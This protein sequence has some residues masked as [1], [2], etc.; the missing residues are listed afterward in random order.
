MQHVQ[1]QS[2]GHVEMTS[3]T[4]SVPS[5]SND[6]I[7]LNEFPSHLD[8]TSALDHDRQVFQGN[9][10]SDVSHHSSGSMK[11]ALYSSGGRSR[12]TNLMFP[13][14][15]R[16]PFQCKYCTFSCP[17]ATNLSIHMRI[18]TGEKPY[19]CG[20]CSYAS[21]RKQNLFRHMATVHKADHVTMCGSTPAMCAYPIGN[22]SSG[23]ERMPVV[24]NVYGNVQDVVLIDGDPV[25]IVGRDRGSF[26]VSEAASSSPHVTP[27]FPCESATSS[28]QEEDV[29]E[30]LPANN[31]T[32]ITEFSTRHY[33]DGSRFIFAGGV[34]AATASSPSPKVDSPQMSVLNHQFDSSKETPKIQTQTSIVSNE[35]PS[36]HVPNLISP[37]RT[38]VIKPESPLQPAIYKEP[39]TGALKRKQ[40]RPAG[41]STLKNI[42]DSPLVLGSKACGSPPSVSSKSL[43]VSTVDHLEKT[44]SGIKII[45]TEEDLEEVLEGRQ[46]MD[47]QVAPSG[48]GKHQDFSPRSMNG[49]S[50]VEPLAFSHLRESPDTVYYPG[51]DT[52]P[53]GTK[54]DVTPS[55]DAILPSQTSMF[56]HRHVSTMKPS[57]ARKVNEH[58]GR[59]G[60]MASEDVIMVE[61][62]SRTAVPPNISGQRNQMQQSPQKT[63]QLNIRDHSSF[64]NK[65]GERVESSNFHGRKT[66]VR[67]QYPN[68]TFDV[69]RNQRLQHG[70]LP[71]DSPASLARTSLTIQ[72]DLNKIMCCAAR[73]LLKAHL[74]DCD[75]C[76]INLPSESCEEQCLT[77]R[78]GRCGRG[79]CS[80]QEYDEGY[81][82]RERCRSDPRDNEDDQMQSVNR[83]LTLSRGLGIDTGIVN[84]VKR[85]DA[86]I[87]SVRQNKMGDG[88]GEVGMSFLRP[89]QP[90]LSSSHN[91]H[92]IFAETSVVSSSNVPISSTYFGAD[93]ARTVDHLLTRRISEPQESAEYIAFLNAEQARGKA[94]SKRK[95]SKV[96]RV[97]DICGKVCH[98]RAQ[99]LSHRRVH[100]ETSQLFRCAVCRYCTLHYKLLKRHIVDKHSAASKKNS[101]TECKICKTAVRV[102]AVALHMQTVHGHV[103]CGADGKSVD[104]DDS[105]KAECSVDHTHTIAAEVQG[106]K[107]PDALAMET[108]NDAVKESEASQ[109]AQEG[110]TTED[111]GSVQ[112]VSIAIKQ[113]TVQEDED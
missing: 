51:T 6:H 104:M 89:K 75:V 32:P 26:P 80:A 2:D 36:I 93:A 52:T 12:V 19:K 11:S 109:A 61:Q 15:R 87:R 33:A 39:I 113:E 50:S 92:P 96:K 42:L 37:D 34:G 18:H 40:G 16:R 84:Q 73:K 66:P 65:T 72:V 21:A 55:V 76:E 53:G 99:L 29:V 74:V 111:G 4:A 3:P 95:S 106:P 108:D 98:S 82:G 14:V 103:I 57:S 63:S 35:V 27:V 25:Q 90:F 13:K 9:D 110:S 67:K 100:I 94:A 79:R 69:D 77:N 107:P 41:H 101:F 49:G 91:E 46:R 56:R 47:I 1:D 22:R 102:T 86:I 24:E 81:L 105:G 68:T 7:N 20:T 59:S 31:S 23:E 71:K 78:S 62:I 64:I 83:K 88:Q 28:S 97:C 45:Q 48:V 60:Q 30:V 58:K 5:T 85:G 43:H 54:E 8:Y 112:D 70:S 10:S 44:G 38:P 17:S